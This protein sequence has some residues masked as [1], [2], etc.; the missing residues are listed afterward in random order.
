MHHH[1]PSGPQLLLTHSILQKHQI[2]PFSKRSSHHTQGI[3]LAMSSLPCW[4]PL[5]SVNPG[6]QHSLSP[7]ILFGWPKCALLY[8]TQTP[9]KAMATR[10]T[11]SLES[12][13]IQS[14]CPVPYTRRR[15]MPPSEKEKCLCYCLERLSDGVMDPR[16][17]Q[18]F[19]TS[20]PSRKPTAWAPAVDLP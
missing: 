17:C 16:A 12:D 8:P 4:Y 6:S 3:I 11:G 1:C 7:M 10:S 5:L 18:P 9:P 14:L 2:T 13:V 20:F 19:P 15:A